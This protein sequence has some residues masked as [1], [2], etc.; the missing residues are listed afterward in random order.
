MRILRCLSWSSLVLYHS[1][2]V[3]VTLS[4]R[5]NLP[6]TK[7]IKPSLLAKAWAQKI[8]AL[9]LGT[10][11]QPPK[12]IELAIARTL[13]LL[14]DASSVPFLCRYRTEIIDPLST[15]QVH[16]LLALSQTHK[17]L[18]PLRNKVI[19]AMPHADTH[20]HETIATTTS[21]SALEDLYA[22]YKPPTKGS[23]LE[24]LQAEYPDLVQLVDDAWNHERPLPNKYANNNLLKVKVVYLL[25]TKI[26]GHSSVMESVMDQVE[27]HLMVQVTCCDS[28]DSK[29]NKYNNYKNFNVPLK[30]VKNHQVLAIRRGVN[31]K[32]LKLS[33][34]IDSTKVKGCIRHALIKTKGRF[35]ADT[36]SASLVDASVHD[37]W[38]RVLRRRATQRAWSSACARAEQG[39]THVFGANVRRALLAPP[40]Y[41]P[42]AVLSL[43]PGFTAGIKCAALDACG[44]VFQLETVPFLGAHN[45]SAMKRLR[46]LT[47]MMMTGSDNQKVVVAIGNEAGAS[48][49]SVMPT[50]KTEFPDE[51]P[52]AIAAISIGRRLQN[53]LHE[54]VKV[55][56]RSLGL[57]MYQ[58][59]LGEKSLDEMLHLTS[60]DAVATVGVDLNSCSLEIL[61]KVPGMQ[62]LAEKVVKKRPIKARVDLLNVAGLGPKTFE[63]CAAFCRVTG[64]VEPL[65][66]TRVH[67]ESYKLAKSLIKTF[68]WDLSVKPKDLPPRK[69]WAVLWEK[70]ITN[71]AKAFDVSTDRVLAVIGNLVDSMMN[72]DPRLQESNADPK[73][74][75]GSVD[76]CVL[77]SPDLAADDKLAKALPLRGIIGTVRNI[78]DFGAFVDF[79]AHSDGLVHTSKL[80]PVLL[81]S[82]LIGQQIGVDVL[83]SSNGKVSLG[84]SGLG[85]VADAPRDY[86]GTSNGLRVNGAQG[87]ASRTNKRSISSQPK[88]SSKRASTQ[89]SNNALTTR[90]G[91][92]HRVS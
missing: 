28:F 53:P 19:Q 77:L 25:A 21:R 26:A 82:L 44:G 72:L 68:A 48:V 13:P 69:D 8:M 3:V 76:G 36:S 92:K 78:A 16:L 75:A 63:N 10:V 32:A 83:S 9:E 50:A 87:L 49:W 18:E 58:H 60:V 71:S 23:I 66:A 24:Q 73:S 67:P 30:Y 54:L 56:P 89:T 65:D 91:K 12:K 43:D 41:P 5:P 33:F 17:S 90:A 46:E 55:P 4:T 39:A 29:Q 1:A 6:A 37:A 81:D 42:Q 38:T 11:Q 47:I 70:E 45:K 57:G 86:G 74:T 35:L 14:E 80:G 22:P 79:G 34:D 31:E 51:S 85:L 88:A 7:M 27:K 2:I 64:G 84:L 52:A 40:L 20:L 59:D 15:Q 62:K 61:Q